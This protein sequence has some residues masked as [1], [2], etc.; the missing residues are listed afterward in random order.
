MCKGRGDNMLDCGA[1]IRPLASFPVCDI[2][3]QT[4]KESRN[5]GLPHLSN[6]QKHIVDGS[7]INTSDTHCVYSK[8]MN[9]E[10]QVCLILPV[11]KSTSFID[12]K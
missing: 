4:Q 6:A 2:A 7:E 10:I 11:H 3:H 8:K 5:S 1:H 9:E 12:V